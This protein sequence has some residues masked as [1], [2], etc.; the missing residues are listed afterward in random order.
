MFIN[1]LKEL[2]TAEMVMFEEDIFAE[3]AV[4]MVLELTLS[5]LAVNFEDR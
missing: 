1:V 3:L 5:P 4:G 2:R